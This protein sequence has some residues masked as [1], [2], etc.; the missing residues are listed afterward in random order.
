MLGCFFLTDAVFLARICDSTHD[1]KSGLR[2]RSIRLAHSMLWIMLSARKV[3]LYPL[4]SP[5][6]HLVYTYNHVLA[7]QSNISSSQMPVTSPISPTQWL[8]K[9]SADEN[10]PT[11]L[12]CSCGRKSFCGLGESCVE[13]LTFL[14][15]SQLRPPMSVFSVTLNTYC[16]SVIILPGISHG[17][18]MILEKHKRH[19]L[20][21]RSLCVFLLSERFWRILYVH[22]S[23]CPGNQRHPLTY[24]G[25]PLTKYG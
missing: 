24:L 21:R 23:C 18:A 15:L 19:C 5:I 20:L 9:M 14:K 3:Q 2:L 22:E 25:R 11:I 6:S 13:K 17:N 1:G 7:I 8:N 10:V 12:N 4:L 16:C